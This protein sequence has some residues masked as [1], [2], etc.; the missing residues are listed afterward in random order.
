MT[1][2]KKDHKKIL[3]MT[4]KYVKEKINETL[5]LEKSC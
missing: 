3:K 5:E 1:A 2:G 4:G